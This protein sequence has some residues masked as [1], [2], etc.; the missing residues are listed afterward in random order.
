MTTKYVDSECLFPETWLDPHRFKV[1][2]QCARCGRK[3][4]R[5]YEVIPKN[6]PP[7]P[8][9]ACVAA[10]AA[11]IKLAEKDREIEYLRRLVEENNPGPA[12][13]GMKNSVRAVDETAKI[14]MEDYGM[15]NLKDNI[16]E[17]ESVAPQLPPQQ[18]KVADSY[19]GGGDANVPVIGDSRQ[20]TMRQ[21]QMHRLG[22]MAIAGAFRNMAVAP[23]AVV[24]NAVAGQPALTVVRTEQLRRP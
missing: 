23:T 4:S 21:K 18:Q 6:D 16:R 20:K 13:V 1:R 14:V 19:F 10:V 7:C 15:T 3:F 8:N 17:G 9:R 2:Y 11:E 24:P 5:T 22:R 12:L